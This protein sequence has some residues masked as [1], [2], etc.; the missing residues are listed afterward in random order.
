[1]VDAVA[2][3][4]PAFWSAQPAV[5]FAQA[6]A[7]FKVR[8]I[9]DDSTKYYYVVA[10]L[11]QQ[12]AGRLVDVLAHPPTENAY[13]SLKA[14]LL[15]TYGLG[16]RD[17]AARLLRMPGLGDRK[18]SALMDDMLSL[19]DGHTPCFLFETLFLEQLP[20]D[21]RLRLADADFVNPRVLAATADVLRQVK[22]VSRPEIDRVTSPPKTKS[23][24]SGNN[25]SSSGVC[26]Y[27]HTFGR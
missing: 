4:L 21:I 1:M 16:R 6:D 23:A 17:R 8:S 2:L 18:P 7:Q 15:M 20:E 27:H 11:D 24:N 3:K 12:T 5:W 19:M 14:R 25:S 13:E 9:K 26:Y 10:V 22:T